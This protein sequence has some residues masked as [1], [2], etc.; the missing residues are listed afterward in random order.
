MNKAIEVTVKAE[1]LAEQSLPV[2]GKYVF[3]YTITIQNLGDVAVQLISRYWHI[4]DA[5]NAIQEVEGLGVVGEQPQLQAG[6]SYT[7]TSGAVLETSTG[8]MEGHYIMVDDQGNE[9]KALIPPFA[10]VKPEALH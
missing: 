6:E 2:E 7:Y 1:Y 10:L 5:N 9:F 4:V 8:T 3:A